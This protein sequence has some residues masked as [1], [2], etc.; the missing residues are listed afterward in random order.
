MNLPHILNLTPDFTPFATIGLPE[1]AVKEDSIWTG[2]ELNVRFEDQ[3]FLINPGVTI[4]TRLNSSDDIMRLF[5][6]TEYVRSKG[7]NKVSVFIPYLPYAR[8]D[9]RCRPGDPHS[10]RAFAKLIN[11]QNYDTVFF[12]DP[13]SH[14]AEAVIERAAPL[15]NVP[16]IKTVLIDLFSSVDGE[17][18]FV[19]PDRG[20]EKKTA[21]L[22][23]TFSV[24]EFINSSKTVYASKD[25]D[26]LTGD[27]VGTSLNSQADLT[28]VTALIV[29]DICDGGRSFFPLA[30]QLKERGV[31]QVVLAVTHGIFSYGFLDNYRDGGIDTVF[32]TDSIRSDNGVNATTISIEGFMPY[33]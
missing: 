25:R 13:H 11:A 26:S 23:K 7:A 9:R 5:H 8:Q 20:A 29:D 18:V 1:I 32:T 31:K 33:V 17:L 24:L 12:V 15:S 14:V 10:L 30:K 27:I 28:G 19:S 4:T 16:F 2:G 22:V 21:E 6:A 3:L